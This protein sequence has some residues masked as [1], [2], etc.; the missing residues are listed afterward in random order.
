MQTGV[1]SEDGVEGDEEGDDP[2]Q[3][4]EAEVAEHQEPT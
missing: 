2:G 4:P 1:V 3:E